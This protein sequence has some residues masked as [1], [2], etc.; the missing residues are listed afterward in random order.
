MLD[1]AM[2]TE[3]TS[4][5]PAI[6]QAIVRTES[7]YNPY[8]IGVNR[9]TR[10]AR[11]P[12]NFTEA[13]TTARRLLAQGANIDMGLGQINSANLQWL[14][15]TVEQAFT[16]CSNLK[17]LQFV[18]NHCYARAGNSGLG[19]R[20][21]RAF[22]CY[23]TGNVRNGFS[24]GYVNKVTNNLNA[25]SQQPQSVYAVGGGNGAMITVQ[26]SNN[27]NQ[28]NQPNQTNPIQNADMGSTATPETIQANNAPAKVYNGWDIFRDF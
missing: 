19:N 28:P 10:L 12:N 9:G 3:C 8:A 20:M 7:N 6:V 13:V 25:I 22:S 18:Y 11:Q 14:G 4:M 24:N 15:L 17:A 5:N 16:P 1:M 2:V 21:Q 26:P 27:Q 23:N